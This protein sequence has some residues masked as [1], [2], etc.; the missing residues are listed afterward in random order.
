MGDRECPNCEE[1]SLVEESL[2][3]WKCLICKEVFDEAFLDP[4]ED[5]Q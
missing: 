2:S 5:E 1:D 3:K 4:E